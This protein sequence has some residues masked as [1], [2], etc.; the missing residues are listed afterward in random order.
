M[1][2]EQELQSEQGSHGKKRIERGKV[3]RKAFYKKVTKVIGQNRENGQEWKW[4][5][6]EIGL[7]PQGVP[8]GLRPNAPIDCKSHINLLPDKIIHREPTERLYY[9]AKGTTNS[10]FYLLK[11]TR[12]SSFKPKP[13]ANFYRTRCR[14]TILGGSQILNHHSLTYIPHELFEQL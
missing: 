12:D 1:A 14:R 7:W 3:Q 10:L 13:F 9:S 6:F 8:N 11:R 2:I 4:R 5:R